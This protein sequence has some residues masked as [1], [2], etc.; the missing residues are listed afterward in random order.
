MRRLRVFVSSPADVD[1]ERRRV[2]QVV[3]RLNGEF[4]GAARLET[5]RWETKYYRAHTTFQAQIPEAAECD[6][7]VA[8]FHARLGTELPPDYKRMPNGEPYPSGSAYEVL[9][10]IEARRQRGDLPDV[11]VFRRPQPPT[12]TLDDPEAYRQAKE[13]WERV[14]AFFE[15][16]F[17]A[18]KGPFKLAFQNFAST[19]D[20]GA[21]LEGLLRQWV[22]EKVLR[23]RSV[24]WPIEVK[25][26]PFRGLA[27]FGAKHASVFFGRSRDIARATDGLKQAAERGTPFLL[28]VGASGAGKSSLARAGLVPRLT[29]PGV[30]PAVDLWRVAVMRPTELPGGPVAALAVRLM[31]AAADIPEE[32][33][34]RP[35]ALPEIAE[36]DYRT[37][38]ELAALLAHADETAAMPILRALDRAAEGER[39]R[40]GY[41]RPLRADFLLVVDQ[42]DELFGPDID[43]AERARCAQV[44]GRLAGTGRVWVIATLRADLYDRFLGDPTLLA[45][46]TKGAA[47]D[48][49]P[50][51]PAELAEIVR[52]PAEAAGLR[53]EADPTT[54]ERL[55]ER[56]LRDADRPDMLP[57]LQLALNRLFDTR[58][59]MENETRLAVA[60]YAALGG[61][62]GV[63][64]RE[65]ERAV[66]SLG[67]DE[68]GP[69]PRLLRQL[70]ALSRD[71]RAGAAT[72]TIRTVPLAAAAPDE[73][74]RWLVRALV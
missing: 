1:H 3:E 50:P 43:A 19:D 11:F 60:A 61:L 30:V 57:L 13:Q 73:T 42:L 38:G 62:A 12:V 56:L 67:E 55:D 59:V 46:K 33:A 16:W 70:A 47:Y 40:G 36:S 24:P 64:D 21:Q 65:A 68:L 17:V 63:I 15:T 39:G 44:L 26:S 51:G 58:T 28:V 41:E 69:L 53:F 54:G 5:V 34:G 37:P 22:E 31:D 4:A 45:L 9:S 7:V 66:A 18:P 49:A 23:G 14:K 25:G 10:A 48:L 20:F 71:G 72:L 29:T 2:E 35:P 8:I 74:S 52:K 6:I 32:D 27:A